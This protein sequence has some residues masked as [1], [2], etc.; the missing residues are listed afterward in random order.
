MNFE[1]FFRG[2]NTFLCDFLALVIPWLSRDGI[3]C[4]T[5]TTHKEISTGGKRLH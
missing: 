3:G 1:P 5:K 2:F 4:V